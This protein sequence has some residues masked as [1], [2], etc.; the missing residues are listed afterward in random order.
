MLVVISDLHFEEEA[1]DTIANPAASNTLTFER[2]LPASAFAQVIANLAGEASRNK[3]KRLDFVLA[4]DIFDLHRTQLWFDPGAAGEP[5]RPYESCSQ[6]TPGSALELKVLEILSAIAAEPRVQESLAVFRRLVNNKYLENPYDP[7]SERDF[8]VA[9]TLHYFPGNHDRLVNATANTRQKVRDLLGL[10]PT[11]DPFTHTFIPPNNDPRVL[12][13]HGH[14]YDLY[15]FP[16]DY[17]NQSLPVKLPDS[18]Y[19]SPTFGDFITVD[20]ACRLPYRFRQV[21]GDDLNI[22]QDAALG[23][24]YL[25]LLEFDDLRPQSALLDFLLDIPDSTL[26][27]EKIWDIILPVA[28]KVLDDIHDDPFFWSW[29]QRFDKPFQPDVMD[30]LEGFLRL[31]SWRL[32]FPL[33]MA[34]FLSRQISGQKNESAQF[35]ARER[36][37]IDGTVRFVIAGHTH[38][39]QVAYLGADRQV[40]QYFVD[41]GTWRNRLLAQSDQT[42]FGRVKAL[43]YVVVYAS[44]EDPNH[45]AVTTKNE[46]FDYWSGFTQRW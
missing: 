5:V 40:E 32:G 16:T 27:Q 28:Q 39:P 36:V 23:S 3:A 37:I 9:V 12:V 41:T 14:E 15:N 25:K 17:H 43:T 35:A 42:A 4:G 33:T 34:K 30:V 2:N 6:V 31:K 46:S 26:S 29:L 8:P 22:L 10:A 21:H 1:Q 13:R 45:I 18:D 19:D 38:E 7:T 20:V 11:A 44:D 24:I